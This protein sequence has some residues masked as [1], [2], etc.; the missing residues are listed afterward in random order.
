[1]TEYKIVSLGKAA[2]A[3]MEYLLPFGHSRQLEETV[4]RLHL[5]LTYTEA[6]PVVD[7]VTYARP[8]ADCLARAFAVGQNDLCSPLDSDSPVAFVISYPRSGNTV[9]IH[10][11]AR[12]LEAQIFEGFPH[13]LIP[14]SKSLYP[15]HYPLTRLI[16]DHVPRL[17]YVN[18]KTV[19][20]VRDG[21]DTMLSLAHMTFKQKRH[22]FSRKGDLS[23]FISWLDREYE[24][25]GWAK[26]MKMVDS[27]LN[28]PDK[29]L[30]RY[31]DFMT[32]HS[33]L[34]KV[35]RF[36][37]PNHGNSEETIRE[38]YEER[39][40]LFE[41]LGENPHSRIEWAIGEKFSQDSLFHDWSLRRQVSHWR[42][43]WD[44]EAK[45]AFHETGATKFLLRYG[46]ET[47]PEWWRPT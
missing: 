13:S 9:L 19:M 24:F 4:A 39:S 42:S 12:L 6:V 27:F 46:Y 22:N 15:K 32:N 17:E 43:A 37:D 11:L 29:I 18:D 16:K 47:D 45:A 40:K 14:F 25:H 26:Y 36:I 30:V 8:I 28:G 21:R 20:L 34:A 31:E 35:A 7:T 23:S 33:V 10:T 41:K 44:A 2:A 1:M 38:K 3:Q 5:A